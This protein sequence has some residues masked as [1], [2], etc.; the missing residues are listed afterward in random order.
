MSART[1]VPVAALVCLAGAAGGYALADDDPEPRVITVT[2]GVTIYEGAD[3]ERIVRR[4]GVTYD[5]F[6]FTIEEK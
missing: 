6:T 1:L 3:A 2:D 4:S 5:T